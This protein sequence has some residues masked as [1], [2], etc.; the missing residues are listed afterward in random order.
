M[1]AI[2]A[3][4]DVDTRIAYLAC[5]GAKYSYVDGK[6][7]ELGGKIIALPKHGIVAALAG[8]DLINEIIQII[9]GS[10]QNNQRE[11]LESIRL[12]FLTARAA[13][14]EAKPLGEAGILNEMVL[15]AAVYLHGEARAA[16]MRLSTF[17]GA[18]GDDLVPRWHE[19]EGTFIPS[20][21]P[22]YIA[23]RGMYV[24]EPV[25]D[26]RALFREQR[27]H[28]FEGLQGAPGVGGT[29]TLYRVGPDGINAT[30]I[31]KFAD[32]VGEIADIADTGADLLRP[33]SI[34]I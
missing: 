10:A 34:G 4:H 24:D 7:I 19:I 29:C 15:I 3:F 21:V 23:D 17:E 9:D 14:Y 32:K 16:I 6:V 11:A 28:E 22:H 33:V 30:D 26:C 31:L 5:D 2:N 13:M 20:T 18:N 27:H 8:P 25:T 1:T 12:A